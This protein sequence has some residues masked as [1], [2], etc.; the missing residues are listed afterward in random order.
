MRGEEGG[1]GAIDTAER[2]ERVLALVRSEGADGPRATAF[3]LERPPPGLGEGLSFIA[4][5]DDRLLICT[6]S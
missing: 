1:R 2:V 4:D 5:A 3:R 6:E